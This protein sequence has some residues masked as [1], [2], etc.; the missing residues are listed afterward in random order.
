MINCQDLDFGK[1]YNLMLFDIYGKVLLE[2][3][4]KGDVTIEL[5]SA[6]E[7]GMYFMNVLEEEKLVLKEKMIIVD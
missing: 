5:P 2:K 3:N 6:L 1:N 7:S 4:F